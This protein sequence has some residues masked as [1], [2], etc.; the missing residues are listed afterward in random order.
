MVNDIKELKN[1]VSKE[2]LNKIMN[3]HKLK[4]LLYSN[5]EKNTNKSN[6]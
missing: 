1:D 3:L 6:H 4:E 5:T 2:L